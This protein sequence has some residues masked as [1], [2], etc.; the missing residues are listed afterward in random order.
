MVSV[1]EALNPYIMFGDGTEMV[2]LTMGQGAGVPVSIDF[3]LRPAQAKSERVPVAVFL[4]GW[5]F[6]KD[7]GGQDLR[8]RMALLASRQ[9]DVWTFTWAD[10]DQK[11]GGKSGHWKA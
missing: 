10:L 1:D 8:Q 11:L 3:A 4:D 7:R 2:N 6:H 9:W 5:E